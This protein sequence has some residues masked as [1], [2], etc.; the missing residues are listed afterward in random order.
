MNPISYIVY[1]NKEEEDDLLNEKDS[2]KKMDSVEEAKASTVV[3]EK[4]GAEKGTAASRKNVEEFSTNHAENQHEVSQENGEEIC[5]LVSLTIEDDQMVDDN[6]SENFESELISNKFQEED[7]ARRIFLKYYKQ[8]TRILQNIVDVKGANSEQWENALDRTQ[9]CMGV[10]KILNLDPE[11]MIRIKEDLTKLVMLKKIISPQKAW[12]SLNS[13]TWSIGGF[14]YQLKEEKSSTSKESSSSSSSSSSGSS[15]E[16][17]DTEDERNTKKRKMEITKDIAQKTSADV[18]RRHVQKIPAQQ[19]SVTKPAQQ[20]SV[21]KRT[22]V[23]SRLGV[24]ERKT[25]FVPYSSRKGMGKEK[26]SLKTQSASENARSK[27]ILEHQN[28]QRAAMSEKVRR[29]NA[30]KGEHSG[31]PMLSK[32]AEESL[33]EKLSEIRKLMN[34]Y[35]SMEKED[36]PK[37]IPGHHWGRTLIPIEKIATSKNYIPP[38]PKFSGRK[39]QTD[40][41]RHDINRI[42]EY[43]EKEIRERVSRILSEEIYSVTFYTLNQVQNSLHRARLRIRQ[44]LIIVKS[45]QTEEMHTLFDKRERLNLWEKIKM[46][47]AN[48]CRALE[49]LA[50]SIRSGLQSQKDSL[51][52]WEELIISELNEVLSQCWYILNIKHIG[53]NY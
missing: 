8:T 40:H 1:M 16:S 52:Y 34:K 19:A 45:E 39:L 10:R 5:T 15:S 27:S 49:N 44:A 43:L 33:R 4:E 3:V 32:D 22:P 6:N 38:A 26:A 35:P 30:E 48:A 17:S 41:Y 31:T 46:R 13:R 2:E 50:E 18:V 21:T 28:C 47:M 37:K 24:H 29:F 53:R 11:K 20:A 51:S 12:E 23:K 36:I 42:P 25:E 14:K 9:N 7:C